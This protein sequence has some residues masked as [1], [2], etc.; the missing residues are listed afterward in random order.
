MS[1]LIVTATNCEPSGTEFVS[2]I[3]HSTAPIFATQFHP[4][5]P[6]YEFKNPLIGHSADV[7]V[8]SQYL[9]NFVASQARMSDNFFDGGEAEIEAHS[10]HNYALANNGY[11]DELYWLP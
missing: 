3:E 6:P 4:E 7:M 2:A 8:V 11:G 5:R 10:V 1:E 9:A